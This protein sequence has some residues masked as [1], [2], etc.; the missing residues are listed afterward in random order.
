MNTTVNKAIPAIKSIFFVC[1][2]ALSSWAPMV[3]FAKNRLNLNDGELGLLLLMLGGGAILM[4][5]ISGYLGQKFGNRIVI[6]I[7]CIAIAFILPFLVFLD[8][9]T[10]MAVALFIFGAGIG[11]VDVSMN[12][13]GVNLQNLYGRP[14]MSSLHGLFS[15]GGLVGSLG[16][17]L[18][19]KTGLEPLHAAV[20]IAALVLLTVAFQYRKLFDASSERQTASTHAEEKESVSGGK[21]AWMNR[22]V[23][24]L[25][26]LCF[27]VFMSEGAMLDWSALFLHEN[28]GMDESW[29]GIGY[30]VFSVA[31]AIMR[32]FGDGLVEKLSHRTVVTG[33]ALTASA[34]LLMVIVSPWIS[35]TILGFFI[36]GC[37]A[38]NIVP[39]FFNEAGKLKNVP[40][41]AAVAAI[42]T[43]G[44]S[45]QLLG[46]VSV[47]FIAELSS[48]GLALGICSLLLAGV[49]ISYFLFMNKSKS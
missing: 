6:T 34:G 9:V 7:S 46:P 48:L 41:A 18:L 31:M 26:M 24:F 8:G 19:I 45:G 17:G 23:L 42:S 13:V 5:P 12:A 40:V 11:T 21:F 29:A 14:I 16:L 33:G 10:A 25:G 32:L 2:F 44:Y 35:L 39:V 37:G 30:A 1:G 4:M 36:L 22:G 20:F 49:G 47:G 28:R 43:M 27:I 38:A 15:V 3:P